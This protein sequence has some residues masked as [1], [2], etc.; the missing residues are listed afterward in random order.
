[1]LYPLLTQQAFKDGG[2]TWYNTPVKTVEDVV[3][4]VFE[5]RRCLTLLVEVGNN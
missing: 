4:M 2:F 5:R 1:M 3:R